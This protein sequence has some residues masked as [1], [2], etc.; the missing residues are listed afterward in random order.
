MEK[1]SYLPSSD[2]TLVIIKFPHIFT[3]PLSSPFLPPF[4]PTFD[5]LRF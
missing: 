3:N 2:K 5:S 1:V 4:S